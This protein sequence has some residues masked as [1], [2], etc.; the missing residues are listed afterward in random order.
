MG[1]LTDPD[2]RKVAVAVM[3]EPS[4]GSHEAGIANLNEIAAWLVKRLDPA[5]LTSSSSC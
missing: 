5:S 3:T 4:G 1:V 2:G